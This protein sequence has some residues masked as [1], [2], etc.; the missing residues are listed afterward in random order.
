MILRKGVVLKGHWRKLSR[1]WARRWDA[2]WDLGAVLLICAIL[3]TGILSKL[4]EASWAMV[5]VVIVCLLLAGLHR[6]PR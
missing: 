4:N 1:D 5:T 3:L 6:R 2:R